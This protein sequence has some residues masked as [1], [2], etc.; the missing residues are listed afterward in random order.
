MMLGRTLLQLD[1]EFTLNARRTL[2]IFSKFER[3]RSS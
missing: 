2:G 1:P 3:T